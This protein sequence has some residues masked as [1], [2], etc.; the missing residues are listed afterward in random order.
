MEKN[1]IVSILCQIYGEL[2][3]K[4]QYNFVNDY[5]NNDFSLSEIAENYGIT[6]QAARDNIVKGENKL[7]EYEEKLHIMENMK[8]Q[9]EKI[10]EII[11]QL[12]DIQTKNFN[13]QLKNK[14]NNIEKKLNNLV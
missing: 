10:N 11:L 6:R 14:L 3:T 13:Y 4:K 12:K 7:F 8:K 2:L 1:V 5:Y 9:E